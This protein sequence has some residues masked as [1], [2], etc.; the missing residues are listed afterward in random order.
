MESAHTF[1]SYNQ[2]SHENFDYSFP[3]ASGTLALK[4]ETATKDQGAK[5]DTAVQ[6]VTADTGLK[7]TRAENSNDVS[8]AIDDEVVFVF[9]CGTSDLENYNN[10]TTVANDAGGHTAII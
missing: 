7:A 8:I 2:I 1:Y 3:S 10:I 5:A 6:T 4:E 9:N